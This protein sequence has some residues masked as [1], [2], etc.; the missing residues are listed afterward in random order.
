MKAY[1]CNGCNK[2]FFLSGH[3]TEHQRI[4]TGVKLYSYNGCTKSLSQ[5]GDLTKHQMTHTRVKPYS[6]KGFTK[7]LLDIQYEVPGRLYILQSLSICCPSVCGQLAKTAAKWPKM[8]GFW[9]FKCLWNHLIE[10]PQIG[11]W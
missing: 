8:I 10:T 3:L 7:S 11:G 4:H 5:A 2:S 1:F 6:C 9:I